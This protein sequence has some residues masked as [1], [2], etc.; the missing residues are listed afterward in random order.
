MPASTSPEPAVASQGGALALIA[1]RAVGRGDDGVGAFQHHDGAGAAR[2]RRGRGRAS[3]A[4]ARSGNSRANSPSCGVRITGR[5]AGGDGGEE[6]VRL[7]R[8]RA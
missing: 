8:R 3:A 7:V 6:R 1:R 5:G 2:Q 4:S